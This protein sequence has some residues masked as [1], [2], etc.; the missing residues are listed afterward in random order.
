MTHSFPTTALLVIDMQQGMADRTRAGR[1]RAN[2]QAESHVAALIALFRARGLPVVHVLHDDPDPTSP[3][4]KGAAMGEPMACAMP[5]PGE[6]V[7]WKHDSSA[8]AGTGLEAHLRQAGIARI[9]LVGAV[10]G[11]CITSTTRWASDRGFTV[12][13][14]GDALIG[15]DI[16]AHAPKAPGERIDAETVLRVTLSLL[17]AD[18]AEVVSAAAVAGLIGAATVPD[19]ATIP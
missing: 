13:L 10:A 1:P 5:A 12:I 9:V 15:F 8:F 11:F 2:P 4:R 17:G 6:T 3:F 14:P 18:F 16:P 7:L 19:A